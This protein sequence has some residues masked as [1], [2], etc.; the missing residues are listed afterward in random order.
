MLVL[1]SKEHRHLKST[2]YLSH[3]TEFDVLSKDPSFGNTN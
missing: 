3:K 1:D 2:P